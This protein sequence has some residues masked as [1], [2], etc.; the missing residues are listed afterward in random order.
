MDLTPELLSYLG[1]PDP[2]L[3]DEIA[4]SILVNWIIAGRYS[5][6]DLRDL[7]DR[8]VHNLQMGL[9]QQGTDKVFVR[10]FSV[11]ILA[12][13][14]YYDN[15]T[16]FLARDEIKALL[17]K[18]L[19]YLDE[20]DDL[21]GYV[22]GKGWAHSCAHTADLVDELAQHRDIDAEDL[23]RILSAIAQKVAAPVAY[24][25]QHNEDERLA[26]AV[27]SALRRGQIGPDFLPNWLAY[28]EGVV[29]RRV[30][31]TPYNPVV[32]GATMN[33][34][35][36]LRSVYFRLACATD[37]PEDVRACLPDMM[38]TVQKFGL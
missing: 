38:V 22:P 17:D 33:T 30:R 14:V 21:R 8:M 13:I 35:Q 24:I 37:L 25:Y 12:G 34:K 23:E 26:V 2:E 11:L 36:F 20:E 15:R 5:P 19:F 32:H 6:D 3:R 7:R 28:L 1:S 16:P 27:H 10:S 9:G 18:T 29:A 4:Y 31:G